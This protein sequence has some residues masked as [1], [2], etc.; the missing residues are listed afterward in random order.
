MG[1][2]ND[3]IH[4]VGVGGRERGREGGREGRCRRDAGARISRRTRCEK[5]EWRM[6]EGQRHASDALVR[7][8]HL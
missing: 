2:C 6:R 4:L 1:V 5:K 7:V 3:A 8:L